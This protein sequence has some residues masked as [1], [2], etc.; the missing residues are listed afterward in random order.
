MRGQRV[1]VSQDPYGESSP[2]EL[3]TAQFPANMGTP[4][5]RAFQLHMSNEL[6]AALRAGF[7][8]EWDAGGDELADE[9]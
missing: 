5:D 8:V 6:T 1:I 7:K 2:L 3:D 9:D 4:S